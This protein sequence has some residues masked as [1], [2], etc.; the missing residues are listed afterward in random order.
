MP[1][2]SLLPIARMK[3]YLLLITAV[4]GLFAL[5]PTEAKAHDFSISVG[6]PGYYEPGYYGGEYGDPGYGYYY[7]HRVYYRPSYYPGYYHGRYYRHHRHYH[8]CE[9][10][11]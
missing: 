7:Y 10:D 4:L 3:K 11:D 6:V 1:R 8:Y 9:D 5:V 2:L